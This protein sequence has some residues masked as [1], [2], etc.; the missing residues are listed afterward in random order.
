LRSSRARRLRRFVNAALLSALVVVVCL[1]ATGAVADGTPTLSSDKLDYSPGERVTL[2]ATGWN[3]GEDVALVVRGSDGIV[4]DEATVEADAAGGFTYEFT[5]P[6]IYLPSYTAEATGSSGAVVSATFTDSNIS[7]SPATTTAS[8]GAGSTTTVSITATKLASGP[9]GDPTVTGLAIPTGSAN[10]C[11]SNSGSELPSAWLSVATPSLPTTITGATQTLTIGVA[12]PNGTAAGNYRTRISFAVTNGNANDVQLCVSVTADT[13]APTGSVSINGNAV[14]TNATSATLALQASDTVGVT[15][16]R[17]ANGSDCSAASYVSVTAATSFSASVSHGLA[18]GDGTKTVCAQFRD[19]GGNQSATVTDTIVL[20][21]VKPVIAATATKADATSYNAGA[22]TNQ[23]VTV[24]FTCTENAGGSGLATSNPISGGGTQSTET[25]SGSFSSGACLDN[26]GNAADAVTFGP[27]KVDK[28]K[29]L[30]SATASAPPGDT[31]YVAGTWTNQ[32]VRVDFSCTDGLSGK[33]TDTVAGTTL[34]AEGVTASVSNTGTCVD[35]AGNT[36]DPASFGPVRIDKTKPVVTANATKA[37]SSPYVPGTWSNQSVTVE[38]TCAEAGSVQSGLA[39]SNPLSGGGTQSS[40][41]STGSFTSGA[42]LDNAGNEAN[43]VTFAPV[44]VDTTNPVVTTTA[45]KADTTPY[46]AGTWTN[47]TVTVAF[48]CAEVGVVQSGLATTNPV[49]GGGTQSTETNAVGVS[50]TSSGACTDNA[51]NH[52][53]AVTFGPVKL[54]KTKPTLTASATT[55]PG[56]APYLPNSW[57]NRNVKVA[58]DCQDALSGVATD[59]VSDVTVV[60]EGANQSVSS[61]G[62]CT[63]EAGNEAASTSF[64]DID[65]DKTAPTLAATA[66]SPPGASAYTAG[67]WTNK[68]VGV[69]FSCADT[70]SGVAT[71]TVPDVTLTDEGS[72]QSVTSTG[73]CTDNAGNEADPATFANVDI[74]KSGPHAP[75]VAADRAPEYAGG[76]G[77]FKDAVTVKVVDT[78]D[79]DLQDGT[80]GSGVDPSSVPSDTVYS[81]SGSHTKSATVKDRAGNVSGSASLTV[82]VDTTSPGFGACVGGPYLL[83]SGIHAVA[84]TASDAGESGVDAAASALAGTVDTSSVG[85]KNVQFTA[86]DNVGHEATKTCA[87]SVIFGFHGFFQPVDNGGVLNAVNAGRAIPVKFD[88]SGNQGLDIFATGFPAS[89][90]VSCNGGTTTDVLEETLTAGSSSLSYSDGQPFGQY[91]YVW[92]TDKA[93][94]GTCRRLDL[95]LLDGTTHS[96]LFKFTK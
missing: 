82:Q 52:A 84:I 66:T 74:D 81:T 79:P 69:A 53:T 44:K 91:H 29:P 62:D 72:D 85:T 71:D 59:S 49:A 15:A 14:A 92:K 41:T 39:T 3:G 80:P 73:D 87:Y 86:R 67:T 11:F 34:S 45:T 9:A 88:L 4:Y 46:G 22:W 19:A 58:F 8:V 24:V 54:D 10:Q 48:T 95:R 47:Q 64:A 38:F 23:S 57:T 83:G 20:D 93:W 35:N 32:S 61:T 12:P 68:S 21:T 7:L 89:T 51:G 26:A 55:E 40:D 1:S 25:A 50:F 78:G 13:A 27:V 5:L 76:G 65:I 75:T 90:A 17:V 96:A 33:A 70:L 18:S 28:T 37:D 43:G 2:S 60:A 77:W 31:A 30:I 42:C 36:A 16:Y 94:A 63:D 6:D 56:G